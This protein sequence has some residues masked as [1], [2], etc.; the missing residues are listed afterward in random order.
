MNRRRDKPQSMGLWLNEPFFDQPDRVNAA[1][2]DLASAGY[3]II[4]VILRNTNFCHRS[5]ETI[6]AVDGVV[7]AAHAL[8]VK[9]VLDCEPHAEPVARDLGGLY[10]NAMGWRVVRAEGVVVDE[11]CLLHVPA[12]CTSGPMPEFLGIEAAFLARKSA[13]EKVSPD[14]FQV[15]VNREFYQDGFTTNS[16]VYT[17]GR[18]GAQRSHVHLTGQVPGV[19]QGRVVA[20]LRF[21]DRRLIDFWSSD[22]WRYFDELLEG[23]RGIP[24]DG[25]GWDEPATGGDW[26]GYLFGPGYEAAFARMHGTP[27]RDRWF[28]LDE[29]GI[30]AESLRVRLDYYRMLNE[31]VFEAQRRLICKARSLFGEDLLLGTHHTWQGEGGINDYRS[32]AV[33]YFRLNDQMDAGYTDCWWW[34]AKSVCYA[35]SLGSSLGR[36]TPSG[37]A[38]VNTWDKKPT[39]AR[40]EY[41]ARLMTLLNITWFNI[42]YGEASDCCQYPADYTWP[43]AVCEMRL[44]RDRQLRLG[45]AKPVVDV[46]ILH[47]WET[48]CG[49][50][51]ADYAAAHKTFCL[52]TAELFVERNVA[53]DW[54]DSRLLAS[55]RTEAGRLINDLGSYAILILPYAAVLPRAAWEKCRQFIQAGGQAIFTG[56]P[57]AWTVEGEAIDAEFAELMD[58]PVLPLARYLARVDATCTLP[59]YRPTRLDVGCELEVDADRLLLSAEGGRHG[60]H[61]AA[62]NAIYLSDLDPRGQLL[63]LIEP[64]LESSIT[65]W[66]DTILWR[67]YREGNREVLV[68]VAREGRRLQ[69]LIRWSGEEIVFDTGTV[70]LLERIRAV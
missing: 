48:V 70:C 31:G 20:Y 21:S 66:S 10:P 59:Q 17:E 14:Y 40:T 23:Y 27:L 5:R 34:D 4:R 54:V 36:L 22:T 46:A 41:Q 56:P 63:D 32:G 12:P 44:H 51:R 62:R 53:F 39:N 58:L 2:Q 60:M 67:R 47:G 30:S 6:R 64:W 45:A 24:L 9:V 69:G 37:E 65:C 29:P 42:W 28:L 16:L 13:Y 7:R 15:R 19:S 25:V 52:N 49:L 33:D 35:Y 3:G 18:M 43:A 11:R 50:N 57:P 55:S 1:V 8:G 61:N 68:C 38:E 26:D